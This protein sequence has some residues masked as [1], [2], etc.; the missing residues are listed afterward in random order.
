VTQ[1]DVSASTGE[2][3]TATPTRSSRAERNAAAAGADLDRSRGSFAAS[4]PSAVQLAEIEEVDPS[5]VFQRGAGFPDW[6][7][8]NLD[9]LA[10]ELGVSGLREVG[11][12]VGVGSFTADLLAQT[13]RGRRVAIMSHLEPSDHLHLGQ[14]IT[15]A[16][17]LD[18]SAVI[19]VTTRIGEEHRAVLDWLNQHGDDEVRF[20]GVELRLLRIGGSPTAATFHVEARPND[21][22]KVIKQRQRVGSPLNSRMREF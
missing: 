2:S 22:Q 9:R 6:L 13:D 12:D 7:S 14:M 1:S 10:K 3:E 21:W 18:V 16:A 20:F 15:F 11:R 5:T 4:S 17:G 8:A 19:W